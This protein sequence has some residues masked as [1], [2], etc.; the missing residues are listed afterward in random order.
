[1]IDTDNN[2]ATGFTAGSAIGVDYLLEGTDLYRYSGGG[3]DWLWTYVTTVETRVVGDVAELRVPR[4]QL[5]NP[6]SM[7]LYFRGDNS[8]LF[9]GGPTD[10]YPDAVS[11]ATADAADRSFRYEF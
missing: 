3:S 8:A 1:M 2:A 11:N 9:D 7:Q 6:V 10:Y 5:N 4:V